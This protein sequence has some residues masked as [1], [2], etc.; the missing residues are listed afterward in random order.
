MSDPIP[1]DDR[2]YTVNEACRDHLRISRGTFYKLVQQGRLDIVKLGSRTI[3]T[4][5]SIRKCR[6]EAA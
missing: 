2:C 4:G 5:R 3:V 1:F 6:G